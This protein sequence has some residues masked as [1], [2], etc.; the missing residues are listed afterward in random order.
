MTINFADTFNLYTLF[1]DYIAGTPLFGFF[2]FAVVLA[3]IGV[4]ILKMNFMT[5]SVILGL[6][7]MCVS[8]IASGGIL[9]LPI[10]I[11]AAVWFI[12]GI[13]RVI[14]TSD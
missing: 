7:I 4:V 3:F 1:A 11:L 9:T 13:G 5:I 10:F 14:G 12:V 6:Y 8:A 2:I